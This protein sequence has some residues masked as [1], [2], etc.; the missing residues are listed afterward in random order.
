MPLARFA[1]TIRL[2]EWVAMF[3]QV[4]P[5]PL[6]GL[7]TQGV[8]DKGRYQSL[9]SKILAADPLLAR[10]RLIEGN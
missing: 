8:N 10:S 1:T 9:G 2:A 3:R 7:P 6:A 4:P 5:K